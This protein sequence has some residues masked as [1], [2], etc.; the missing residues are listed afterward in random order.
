MV[1]LLFS[2][3]SV[4]L[5]GLYSP[6]AV[7]ALADEQAPDEP[8]VAAVAAKESDHEA[9]DLE[10]VDEGKEEEEVEPPDADR[11]DTGNP[12]LLYACGSIRWSVPAEKNRLTHQNPTPHTGQGRAQE[13]CLTVCSET[14]QDTTYRIQITAS[15]VPEGSWRLH[16][17][18]V[19]CRLFTVHPPPVLLPPSPPVTRASR[20]M[21]VRAKMFVRYLTG[22]LSSI[23]TGVFISVWI[24]LLA[25]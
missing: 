23:C 7:V 8:H 10:Q 1:V 5:P 14:S 22:A 17:R 4:P 19:Y 20:W 21:W 18:E 12:L 9:V 3:S 2:L 11:S 25:L 16:V 15:V 13:Y 6:S 24:F